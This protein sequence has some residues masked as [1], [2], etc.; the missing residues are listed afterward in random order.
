MPS[1]NGQEELRFLIEYKSKHNSSKHATQNILQEMRSSLQTYRRNKNVL[2]IKLL[3]HLNHLLG[4]Y[5]SLTNA[6]DYWN[7]TQDIER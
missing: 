6:E 7:N 1:C 3:L 2:F 5:I 4:T